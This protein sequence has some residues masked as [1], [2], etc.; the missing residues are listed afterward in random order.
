MPAYGLDI[1]GKTKD[2]SFDEDGSLNFISGKDRS[3]RNF[4]KMLLTEAGPQ[5]QE[6]DSDERYNPFFGTRL[7]EYIGGN[8]R[9]IS[10]S[11]FKTITELERVIDRFIQNQDNVIDFM[12]DSEY[13]VKMH[14]V[15]APYKGIGVYFVIDIWTAKDLKE[16]TEPSIK[17]Q[18]TVLRD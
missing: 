12:E 15:V 11:V 9:S 1:T 4:R 17:K 3:E 18:Y 16:G 5:G 2:F 13:F 7:D 6:V 14:P 8:S 10:E